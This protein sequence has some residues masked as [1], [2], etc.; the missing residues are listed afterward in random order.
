VTTLALIEPIIT[1]DNK[2]D[3]IERVRGASRREVERL[4]SEYRPPAALRD[5]IR[6]V[7]VPS[8]EPRSIEA[9]LWD[10]RSARAVPEKYRDPVPTEERV[11]VQFLA[12]DEFLTLFE[13][14]RNLIPD[15]GDMTF[16]EMMKAVLVEYRDRRSPAAR[17]ARRTA[18]K[19]E[20]SPDSHRWEWQ[21]AQVE[22]SRH[23][24]DE[25]RDEVFVRDNAEC[26][27]MASDGTRCQCKKGL[28]IDHIRPYAAGGTHD[29]SNL[30]LLC[31]AHNR[32]AAERTL[33]RHVMQ[34][35]WRRQ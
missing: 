10:R 2:D 8:P 6:Y 9:A 17:H 35:F 32:L 11:F 30:R 28:Q 23:V 24:P 5:R 3:I 25:I 26:S 1:D 7:Q 16:A 12:D 29:P 18:K 4:L 20:E 31:G 22:P 27:F 19:R 14:V 13:E 33:G 34:P 15:D 21:N